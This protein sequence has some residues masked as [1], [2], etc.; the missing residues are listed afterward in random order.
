M[1]LHILLDL[2]QG[3]EKVHPQPDFGGNKKK[4]R[5][6]GTQG[7]ASFMYVCVCWLIYFIGESVVYFYQ[8]LKH[9]L[10]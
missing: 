2:F 1:W 4:K 6:L 3:L 5:D 10:P 8:N 9:I 7:I